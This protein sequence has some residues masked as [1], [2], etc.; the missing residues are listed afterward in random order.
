MAEDLN[1]SAGQESKPKFSLKKWKRLFASIKKKEEIKP[2]RG[3]IIDRPGTGKVI[4][5]L[6]YHRLEKGW[7][8]I[9]RQQFQQNVADRGQKVLF[10]VIQDSPVATGEE[11][12]VVNTQ[13][14]N[15]LNK[16]G[17]QVEIVIDVHEHP[18]AVATRVRNQWSLTTEDQDVIRM[19]ASRIEGLRTLPFDS[20]SRRKTAG[21]NIPYA[22]TDPD[23]PQGGVEA[24]LKGNVTP[25]MQ[26]A[27]NSNLA[28]IT[29]L[30]NIQ[31][32]VTSRNKAPHL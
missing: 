14:A 12:Q 29:D 11:S 24:Y 6:G 7:G 5:V 3:E 32:E 17:D 18:E 4:V 20:Y 25:E 8:Q 22:I 27:I 26:E 23:L 16:T 2:Y 19:T 9:V 28:F 13:I 10:C 15:F 21:R 31:L 30:A 1:E